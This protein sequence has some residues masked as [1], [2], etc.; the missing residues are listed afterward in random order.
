VVAIGGLEF[1]DPRDGAG[2]V[3]DS[4]AEFGREMGEEWGNVCWG[5]WGA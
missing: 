2:E 1:D 4:E 5:C 3:P